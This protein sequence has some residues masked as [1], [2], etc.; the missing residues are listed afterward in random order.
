MALTVNGRQV[1]A[2]ATNIQELLA[3]LNVKSPDQV[4]VELNGEILERAAYDSAAV[5]DGDQIEFLYFMGGGSG[6][7]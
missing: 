2:A 3:E 5:R 7:Y 1:E 6:A 4:S